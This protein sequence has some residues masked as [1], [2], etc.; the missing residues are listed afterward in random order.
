VRCDGPNANRQRERRRA[1][2]AVRVERL[3]RHLSLRLRWLAP[4][5]SQRIVR[6]LLR[7]AACLVSVYARRRAV[8]R[9]REVELLR[10]CRKEPSVPQPRQQTGAAGLPQRRG[11]ARDRRGV[12]GPARPARHWGGL[13]AG[14]DGDD[15]VVTY[16][17]E[18]R[19]RADQGCVAPQRL[20]H[21]IAARGHEKLRHVVRNRVDRALPVERDDQVHLHGLEKGLV[22]QHCVRHLLGA[23]HD[24]PLHL[25]R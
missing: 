12:S 8:L 19:D 23:R 17:L 25:F 3:L 22:Q 14:L 21:A 6:A 10:R 7:R 16:R 11:G 18:R 2:E 9:P 5:A 4:G 13:R 15:E 24:A 1:E 20:L